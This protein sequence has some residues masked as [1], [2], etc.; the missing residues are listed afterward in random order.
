VMMVAEKSS[1]SDSEMLFY[2]DYHSLS[3]CKA[4]ISKINRP[5]F[6]PHDFWI[7]NN[8]LPT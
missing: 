8:E 2:C 7:S 5:F 6:I 4:K 1:A 3:T